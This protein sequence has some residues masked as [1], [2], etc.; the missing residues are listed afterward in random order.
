[1][2][3]SGIELGRSHIQNFLEKLEDFSGLQKS[4]KWQEIIQGDI[5]ILLSYTPFEDYVLVSCYIQAR[6]KGDEALQLIA[7]KLQGMADE[8]SIKFVHQG[9]PSRSA[10]DELFRRTE[11]Y[12]IV[13]QELYP[14]W[15]KSFLPQKSA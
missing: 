14:I 2:V 4:E 15:Q 5:D 7:E 9:R 12:E 8:H 13:G 11:G 1:M 10:S 3:N 6:K